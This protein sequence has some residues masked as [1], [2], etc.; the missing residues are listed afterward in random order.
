MHRGQSLE[1]GCVRPRLGRTLK[2]VSSRW[3][4]GLLDWLEKASCA[5]DDRQV[6][7]DFRRDGLV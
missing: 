3:T 7:R 2:C 1:H 5:F 4:S 6:I